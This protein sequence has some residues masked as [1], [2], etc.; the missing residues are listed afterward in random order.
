MQSVRCWGPIEHVQ[1]RF[2]FDLLGYSMLL[3]T[4]PRCSIESYG[5][6]I[7]WRQSI[8]IE[9]EIAMCLRIHNMG[10]LFSKKG[11]E[12]KV[13]YRNSQELIIRQMED[14]K[15]KCEMD[16]WREKLKSH[17]INPVW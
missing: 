15:R 7:K 2:G 10:Y 9:F 1:D 12:V 11:F 8:N 14:R 5:E 16:E 6:G 3:M 13:D 4:D 17:G